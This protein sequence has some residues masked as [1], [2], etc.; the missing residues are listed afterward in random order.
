MWKSVA[1]VVGSYILSVVL[2][3]ASDPI[4]SRIF[5]GDFAKGNIPSNTALM[6][7]TALFVLASIFC[8]WVCARFSPSRPEKHVLWFFI[9]GEVM[10]IC[11]TIVNWNKGYPHWYLIAW[12]LTFPVSC[13]I[14]LMLVRRRSGEA[15][16]IG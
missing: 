11:A 1:V 9:L 4:L 13:W 8:G 2:V 10:G 15:P 12:L 6:A 7:S 14:G 3:L 16:A 5:P